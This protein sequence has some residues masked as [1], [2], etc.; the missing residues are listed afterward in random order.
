MFVEFAQRCPSPRTLALLEHA[1]GAAARVA[2]EGTAFPTRR[3]GMDLVILSL[4]TDAQDD[5]ANIAWTRSFYTAMQPWSAKSVYVNALSEDDSS[6]VREAFGGNFDRLREIK[7]KYDPENRFQRN[8]NI[9]PLVGRTPAK[10][11]ERARSD[12]AKLKATS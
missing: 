12:V 1:H 9:P 2:S 10:P 8:Q 3:E 5:A 6:R 4:W 7:T 11:L